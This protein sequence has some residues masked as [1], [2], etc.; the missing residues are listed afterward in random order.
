MTK[1]ARSF[2]LENLTLNRLQK[3]AD[4]YTSNTREQVLPGQKSKVTNTD[5]IDYLINKAYEEMELLEEEAWA[6]KNINKLNS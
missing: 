4:Y 5:V 1:I 2:R 6:E 3:L